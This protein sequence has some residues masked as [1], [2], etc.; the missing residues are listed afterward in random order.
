MKDIKDT[1]NIAAIIL[2]AGKGKRM[3]SVDKNKV[4]LQLGDKPLIRHAV[5]LL[6]KMKFTTIV[7]V[8]GFAKESVIEALKGTHV[9]FTEQTEQ[10]GTAHA[11][12]SGIAQIPSTIT[13][14]LVIQG[15]DSHF[16]TESLINQLTYAHTD[17][18]AALTMLTVE[19]ENP[20]GLGRIVRDDDGNISA[21]VEEK[22]ATDAQK[23]I[24]EINPACYL[25]SL[26]FLKTYLPLVEKS[27]VTGEY[28]LTSLIDLA[29][30][31]GERV[32]TVKGGKLTWRGVNTK[33]DLA[34]AE[35][36]YKNLE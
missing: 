17:S 7:I 19:A 3:Q 20:S 29:I 32:N 31:H 21:V 27:P 34:V 4:T 5:D 36:L 14:V 11:V 30:R 28:Y 9:T 12:Q 2:A 16:Y 8:V 33:E 13:D 35:D 22:D 10:L 23:E 26:K 15:D 1:N 18:N 24:N 6:E 25:F